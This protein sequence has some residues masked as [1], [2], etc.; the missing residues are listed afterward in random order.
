MT[1]TDEFGHELDAQGYE[2]APGPADG[3]RP[4][5]RAT[6]GRPRG[7]QPVGQPMPGQPSQD[8]PWSPLPAA[9]RPRLRRAG[10]RRAAAARCPGRAD[11]GDGQRSVPQ[12]V[13]PGYDAPT[14]E[15]YPLYDGGAP[16]DY[17]VPPASAAPTI[18]KSMPVPRLPMQQGEAQPARFRSRPP[19]PSRRR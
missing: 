3:V 4:D 1:G 8:A 6:P 5:Q 2:R 12:S 7:P 9:R 10:L 11:A 15:F 18:P 16:E 17:Q 13:P 14:A 19:P